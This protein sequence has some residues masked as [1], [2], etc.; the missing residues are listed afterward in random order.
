[1]SYHQ[2][3]D[4]RLVHPYH[5]SSYHPLDI[6]FGL[7]SI[8]LY[9]HSPIKWNRSCLNIFRVC[10]VFGIKNKCSAVPQGP[11]RPTNPSLAVKPPIAAKVFAARWRTARVNSFQILP[12]QSQRS[13]FAV[14]GY[15]QGRSRTSF[16][17]LRWLTQDGTPIGD[18]LQNGGL[19]TFVR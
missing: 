6:P 15:A 5:V 11:Y 18:G 9:P 1:M 12:N 4:H 2:V 10:L 13:S 19:F 17:L 3:H 8:Y 16:I 7:F 14:I